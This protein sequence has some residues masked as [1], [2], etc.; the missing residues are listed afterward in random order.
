MEALQIFMWYMLI[1]AAILLSIFGVDDFFFDAVYW[2]R[3]FYRIWKTRKYKKLTYLDLINAEEKKI[4]LIIPCWQEDEVIGDML[5]YNLPSIDYSRY[6][7]Y[8]NY[9]V[10]V[11]LYPNDQK[12]INIVKQLAKEFGHLHLA[13]APHPGP[14]SKADNLNSV[15]QYICNYEK[16]HNIKY[17]IIVMHDAEDIIHPLS[18]KL[19]NFLIPRKDMIQIPVFPLAISLWNFTHWTYCDEF[20]EH[21]TKNMVVRETLKGFVPSAGVSTAFNKIAIDKLAAEQNGKPFS[22]E[23]VT[24]DYDL[25]L[26]LQLKNIKAI[27]LVQTIERIIKKKHWW[28]FGKSVFTKVK[29]FIATRSL[30]PTQYDASIRQRSRWFFGIALQEWANIGW[31]GKFMF[32]Y[33]LFHDRKSSIGIFIVGFAYI[34]G[35]YWIIIYILSLTNPNIN[36]LAYYF[37]RDPWV[38]ILILI[39]TIWMLNR[40]LQRVIA[41]TRVYG[42]FAGLMSILRIVYVNIIGL[43]VVTRALI[44]F[45]TGI[46]ITRKVKW[47]KT[48][49]RFPLE[50]QLETY[51]TNIG[52]ILVRKELITYDDLKKALKIQ[53]KTGE[54]IGDILINQKKITKLQLIQTLAYEYNVPIKKVDLSKTLSKEDLSIVPKHTY[55][56]LISNQIYPL[57]FHKNALILASVDFIPPKL[58]QEIQKK[59]FPIRTKFVIADQD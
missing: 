50:T 56:W 2:S 52:D 40:I 37:N 34:V 26:R 13:I 23:S 16:E 31:P 1:I 59:I 27:F 54:K 18:F 28:S 11:G 20:A 3:Y 55:E 15:Y 51:R 32:K 30:F 17:D 38:K 48:K 58:Q 47:I 4:A 53:Q 14:T 8:T 7:D 42:L 43:H 12:S 6:I 57:T 21:H 44:Y 22:A 46:K 19:Y 36:N 10:F 5:R 9:D 41:T 29:E 33:L 35:I 25:A 45:T 49:N 24:E 39:S